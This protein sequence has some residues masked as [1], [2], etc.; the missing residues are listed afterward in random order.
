MKSSRK[1]SWKRNPIFRIFIIFVAL[2]MLVAAVGIGLTYYIFFI[3]EPEGLS[4]ASWPQR[5]TDNFSLWME[6]DGG[7]LAIEE[8]GL[9]RLDR[10]G[11]WLQVLDESGREVFAHSKPDSYPESYPASELAALATGAFEDGYTV[12]VSSFEDSGETWNY[13]IGFPYA[14]GKYM[15]YYNGETVSRL[16]PVF[17][18]VLVSAFAGAA[19]LFLVYGFWI[20]RKMGK[21]TRGIEDISQRDYMPLAEKGIFAGVYR[22]LNKMDEEI[23][24]SDRLKEE[25]ERARREWI[26]NITHDLKT[27]LSPVRGYAELLADG[28][29]DRLPDGAAVGETGGTVDGKMGDA[30]AGP[31]DDLAE[32]FAAEKRTVREYG[33]I[34]LKNVDYAEKLINDL[35]LTYQLESGAFPFHPEEVR[36]VRFLRELVIDIAND[37]AYGDRDIEFESEGAEFT[38]CID[39]DLFR[40]AV[41]NLVVNALVHNPADTKVT[42]AVGKHEGDGIC[43]SVRDNGV[44]IS[45]EEQAELFTRYYRGTNTREKPEGSG[46]GLAIAKQI[47]VLHGGY[48]TVKS[49]VGEGTEFV[50]HLPA[51]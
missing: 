4:Q 37:P 27:P 6:N 33:A 31:K 15:L 24:R 35:K 42:V 2:V 3:P 38:A 29:A 21:I 22:A 30:T 40:R 47:I 41:G 23:R 7:T 48:I 8:I 20:I 46:L 36:M 39:R 44:G 13:L 11:L 14:V 51:D 49:K 16:S 43:I 34:I 28:Q 32:R 19:A 25:T 10:Y 17:R 1:S 26:T 9:D 5:F 45:E 12:F 50:I 18:L